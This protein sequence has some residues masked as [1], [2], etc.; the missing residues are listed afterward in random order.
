MDAQRALLDELMGSAR[1][2]TEE[3]RK[4]HREIKWDD[5]D[6][7]GCYMV[8]FCP[9]DLFVNTR[10]DLGVC[11]KIHDPK[12]KESF[13][14]S[15]RHDSYVPKFE[16]E[17]SQF[18]ER[19]VSDLDRRVRRGRERLAQ[20]VEVPPPPPIS[21]EKAEQL[22]VLEEKIKNL[23][24][25]VESLGEAGKVDEAEALMRKVELLNIEKTALTQ[26]PQ[27]DKLLLVAQEK[28]MAL[29]EICGSFLVA[30]D[31]AE[32]TQSHVTGKQHMGYGMVREFLAE[33]KEAKEK[34]REDERL[35]REKEAEERRKLREKEL[36]SRNRRSDSADRDR[37]RDHGRSRERNGRGS[38]ELGRG[39][40]R[41]NSGSS[42]GR[43]G[44][45]DRY[46][47]RERSRSR[48][49]HRHNSRRRSSR[50]PIRP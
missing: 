30:N 13:E 4:G 28:K 11:P 3:E 22:S 48:S 50:S 19:L 10:S 38:R 25:Q 23:L 46:R 14:E 37:Y 16:A 21:A 41:R 35:A 7:C 39:A 36:E 1:N 33:Y 5:K 20:D 32:R 2:L 17:L 6:V 9:H 40:D 15:P 27:P 44:S 18:C 42:N 26:P 8:R 12:L 45:R 29:C 43:E 34:A 24:E 47:E 31:A 49:P